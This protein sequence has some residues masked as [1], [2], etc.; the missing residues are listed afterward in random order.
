[1]QTLHKHLK[2]DHKLKHEGRLQ[3]GRFLKAGVCFVW[4]LT[5]ASAMLRVY[6]YVW[7]LV[8]GLVYVGFEFGR[9]FNI[10]GEGVYTIDES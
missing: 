4:T 9:C 10:L 7:L 2:E 3:Y 5:L 8:I 6:S 1:M